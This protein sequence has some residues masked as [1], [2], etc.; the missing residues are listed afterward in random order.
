MDYSIL[1]SHISQTCFQLSYQDKFRKTRDKNS[2]LLQHSIFDEFHSILL[3][4]A[5]FNLGDIGIIQREERS[6]TAVTNTDVRLIAIQAYDFRKIM[7]LLEEQYLTAEK[8]EPPCKTSVL[9]KSF[10][11]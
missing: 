11:F 9:Q 10:V 4:K 2:N 5:I 7:V 3:N 6:L 8:T 1:H